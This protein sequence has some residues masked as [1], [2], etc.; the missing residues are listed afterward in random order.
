[1]DVVPDTEVLA[2]PVQC[3]EDVEVSILKNSG[4]FSGNFDLFVWE[5]NIKYMRYYNF[6]SLSHRYSVVLSGCEIRGSLPRR[7]NYPNSSWTYYR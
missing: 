4:N 2:Y 5:F 6:H 1:M 7:G 3:V